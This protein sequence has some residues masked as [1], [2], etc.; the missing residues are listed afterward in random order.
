MSVFHVYETGGLEGVA[1]ERWVCY[2]RA[3][4]EIFVMRVQCSDCG[5]EYMNLII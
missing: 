2:K 3:A 5:Y 1:S 4:G